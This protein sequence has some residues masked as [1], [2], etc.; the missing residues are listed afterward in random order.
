MDPGGPTRVN[1]DLIFSQH[2][3]FNLGSDNTR[4]Y[5]N[6]LRSLSTAMTVTISSDPDVVQ[7]V[8]TDNCVNY[9]VAALDFI[10]LEL[11]NCS[12]TNFEGSVV[13]NFITLN[14]IMW[15]VTDK[16]PDVCN[17]LVLADAHKSLWKFIARKELS[18]TF[19]KITNARLLV[20]CSLGILHNILRYCPCARDDY[21]VCGGIEILG[22]FLADTYVSDLLI[23][24][25]TAALFAL[26]SIVNENESVSIMTTDEGVLTHILSALRDSLQSPPYYYSTKYGYHAAEIFGCLG[27]L[28]GPDSNKR[29]LLANNALE[30][31]SNALQISLTVKNGAFVNGSKPVISSRDSYKF[32]E[33][34]LAKEAIDLLWRLSCLCEVRDQLKETSDL[35]KLCAQFNDIKWKAECRKSVQ[36]LLCTLSQQ[37]NW[38]DESGNLDTS[39][40]T[41]SPK[42]HGHVM[43]SY[44]NMSQ[45]LVTKLK[46]ALSSRGWRVWIFTDHCQHGSFLE[47]MAEA[48]FD[49][50]AMILCLSSSYNTS[51]HC[52]KEV[53]SAYEYHIPLLPVVVEPDYVPINFIRFV[54]TGAQQIQLFDESHVEDAADKLTE[55]LQCYGVMRDLVGGQTHSSTSSLPRTISFS[56][57]VSHFK[58]H[59]RSKSN[60]LDIASTGPAQLETTSAQEGLVP[61]RLSLSSLG[62]SPRTQPK[63]NCCFFTFT[64]FNDP[65]P[66]HFPAPLEAYLAEQIPSEAVRLW[67][68]DRVRQ[69]LAEHSLSHY[70]HAFARMNGQHLYELAWHRIRGCDSF[71]RNLGFGIHMP[72]YEQLLLSSALASLHNYTEL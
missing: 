17:R 58:I 51:C 29:N 46:E 21:R 57:S 40:I 3:K 70:A 36:A 24:L 33:D 37:Q 20:H 49:S 68:E 23:S 39:A 50:A 31:I 4:R 42:P 41:A 47:H 63:D 62:L 72:L 30:L 64:P 25:K 71:F 56:K 59:Q 12:S 45:L 52:I 35:Y 26:A 18:S 1:L 60:C 66:T 16:S 55:Q 34:I 27:C 38:L 7:I 5:F 8:G 6:S 54:L 15:N 67:Q 9:F 53:I 19:F 14:A 28:A 48:V 69:W 61:E 32:S 10:S 13:N 65:Y 2:P 43:I 11:H 22:P 44:N